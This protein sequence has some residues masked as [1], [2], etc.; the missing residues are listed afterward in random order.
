MKLSKLAEHVKKALEEYG[1]LE[2]NTLYL[3][4]D[5]WMSIENYKSAITYNEAENELLLLIG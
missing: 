4:G 1:D 3:P 5:N 2:I